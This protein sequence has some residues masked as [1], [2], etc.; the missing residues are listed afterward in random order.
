MAHNANEEVNLAL[1]S[2]VIQTFEPST[3]QEAL[4]SEPWKVVVEAESPI[5]DTHS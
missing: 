5:H 4:E 3:L 1:M 2:T